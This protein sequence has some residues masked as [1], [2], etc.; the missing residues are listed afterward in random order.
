MT[1]RS[2]GD[3][4]DVDAAA[5]ALVLAER[6]V[7]Y[8]GQGV[9]YAEATEELVRLAELLRAPVVTTLE[10]K[11]A[12]PEDHPLACGAAGIAMSGPTVVAL[13]ESDA[14]LAVGAG[15][16]RHAMYP[17]IPAGKTIVHC[18]ND[19]RDLNKGY[20]AD[21]PIL[22]DAKLVLGQL[23]EAVRER[24][25]GRTREPGPFHAEI[26]R[27][28]AAWL[29]EWRP[30]L[31]SDET[32]IT[33]YRVL[34]ELMR[35]IPSAD[36]IVTHDSGSP[37][38]QIVPFYVATR[39]RGY[40]GWGKSHALGT[41]L[42]LTMGAKLAAPDKVCVNLMGDAAF[43]MTGLDFETAI[44]AGIPIITVVLNNATMA[45]EIDHLPISHEKYRTRDIGGAYAD[46]ARALGP[47]HAETIRDPS[48]IGRA[49]RD[50]RRATEDGK[51][52][53]LEVIT[54]AETRFSNRRVLEPGRAGGH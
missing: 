51:P 43:G 2:A 16:T 42:G 33:P 37:R 54:S 40:L 46:L 17:T 6:P 5:G 23:A 13:R 8:A 41:G 18:T 30:I 44:R 7:I 1:G 39:P 36:A 21:A 45:I 25:G 4:R 12:F 3:P 19:E 31:T 26:D 34:H 27:A 28:R 15:L 53:L 50:A 49:F 47:C 9:L 11:S 10:G 29:T 38:D 52:A 35:A 22:G 32:P 48:D 20:P 14:L 24:L